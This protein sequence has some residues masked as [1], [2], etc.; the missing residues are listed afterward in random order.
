MT[1]ASEEGFL[2]FI[3]R[4]FPRESS[5][6]LVGRGDDCAVIACRED[7]C[8]TSDLFLE[9]VHFRRSYFSAADIG[10]KALAVNISDIA[11][12]G[13]KPHGFTL[14]LMIPEG[15]TESFWSDFFHGM[16]RLATEHGLVLAG[17]DLS[18]SSLLGIDVAMWGQSR[19]RYLQRQRCQPGDL[20]FLIGE[21]GLARAGLSVLEGGADPEAFPQA[22]SAHLRPSL[23][24]GPAEALGRNDRVKGLMDVSDGL[25]R[26]L[27]RFLGVGRGASLSFEPG[28]VHEEVSRFCR[29]RGFSSQE[30]AFLGGEDYALLGA[31][32]KEAWKEVLAAA[33][34]ARRI[35]MVTEEPGILLSGRPVS[36]QGFDHFG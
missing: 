33:P 12:M 4:F 16:S 15:L 25:A 3:D 10:Y 28:T 34:G 2:Q 22:V 36:E 26:D 23:H 18:R 27:P 13:A 20:L 17:G 32:P 8:L 31:A 14:N 1:L 21:I 29:E 30:F 7:L 11:A 24:C 19:G 35:G 6:L 5:H 9:D